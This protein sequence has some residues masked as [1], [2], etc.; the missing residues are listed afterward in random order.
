MN[1]ALHQY[2]TKLAK[3]AL[4][5]SGVNA[6]NNTDILAQ[7]AALTSA[8]TAMTATMTTLTNAV[9]ALN[10][11]YNAEYAIPCSGNP[12]TLGL[13]GVR[14]GQGALD[15]ITSRRYMWSDNNDWV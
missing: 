11:Q 12:N 6:A 3:T 15:L 10:I 14:V 4:V 7:L 2:A 9:N 5:R 13:V 1:F 8:L